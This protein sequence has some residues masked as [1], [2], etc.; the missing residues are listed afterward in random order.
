MRSDVVTVCAADAAAAAAA[1]A[2]KS[3]RFFVPCISGELRL[4]CAVESPQ[5][6]A[7]MPANAAAVVDCEDEQRSVP[8]EDF[9]E[10]LD[11][12]VGTQLEQVVASAAEHAAYAAAEGLDHSRTAELVSQPMAIAGRRRCLE[13]WGCW[14]LIETLTVCR[15][16]IDLG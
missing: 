7:S 6:V 4:P 16:G 14:N 13:W 8:P 1:A 12:S 15:C 9:L 5:D 2:A 11:S 3:S 10:T